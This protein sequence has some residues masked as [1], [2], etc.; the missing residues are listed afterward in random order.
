MNGVAVSIIVPV[1]KKE[2][3]LE[4][5]MKSLLNQTL[6]NIEII[7]VDDGSPDACPELCEAYAKQDQRVKVIHKKN[8][9]LG[10]ARNQG[11][12]SAK[13]EFVAFVDSDDYVTLDMYQTLYTYAVKYHL[14][15]VISGFFRVL[16]NGTTLTRLEVEKP[17][18]YQG[19]DEAKTLVL[20]ML[21][22]VP[23][24]K[25]DY[26]YE[27]SV[28][29][30]LY[31]RDIINKYRVRFPS[32]REYISEDILFHFDYF[33]YAKNIAVVPHALYYYCENEVS[34]TQVYRA[35]RFDKNKIL[36]QKI[37][38]EL[39]NKKFNSEAKQYADRMLL[40]RIRGIISQMIRQ[41]KVAGFQVMKKEIKAIIQDELTQTIMIH[42]PVRLLPIKQRVFLF[43]CK[44]NWIRLIQCFVFLND[45]RIQNK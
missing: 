30:G 29:R 6:T 8:E 44:H 13:G 1:Y 11:L 22:S 24:C 26:T 2:K 14:D 5:C 41:M 38:S 25:K 16:Y 43:A 21:G 39:R 12:E 15:T 27:M 40:A 33:I 45:K 23:K 18:F 3:Y 17:I 35:D 42:Y 4:R 19:R 32:E 34:L 37:V 9:G 31:A 7:L 10:Y 36:Y 28:W 20:S